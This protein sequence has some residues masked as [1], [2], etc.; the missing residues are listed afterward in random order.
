MLPGFRFFAVAT[1]LG[2]A[3]LIFGVGAAALLRA[4]HQVAALSPSV[5]PWQPP[6]AVLFVGRQEAEAPMLSLL[7][8]EPHPAEQLTETAAHDG[9]PV[10]VRA[11]GP[12]QDSD[13]RAA[14]DSMQTEPPAAA[15]EIPPPPEPVVRDVTADV[16]AALPVLPAPAA[17]DVPAP[18][19]AQPAISE[20]PGAGS[21]EAPPPHEVTLPAPPAVVPETGPEKSTLMRTA[22]LSASDPEPASATATPGA[23]EAMTSAAPPATAPSV[24][25]T[26]SENVEAAPGAL[27][28][29]PPLPRARP[30]E[31]DIAARKAAAATAAKAAR[32]AALRRQAANTRPPRP[33][34]APQPHAF[35]SPFGQPFAPAFGVTPGR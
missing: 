14:M 32:T 24:P 9:S 18:P 28:D 2:A 11:D 21:Q 6:P 4:T 26:A 8:V 13:D 20:K 33:Q 30:T 5:S 17:S 19:A 1:L 3:L 31:R 16:L 23:A 27:V 34:A 22:A 29:H 7:R 10:K 25:E 15:A 12:A 35:P